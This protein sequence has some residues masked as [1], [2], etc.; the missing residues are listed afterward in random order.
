M[1]EARVVQLGSDVY[2]EVHRL[3]NG[4]SFRT[5]AV[6]LRG[7]GSVV[8]SPTRTLEPSG[9]VGAAGEPRF[10]L[11]P[12]HFHWLGIP[13]WSSA[14]PDAR[15]V[16]TERA[17]RRLGAKLR[18]EISGLAE[19]SASLPGEVALLEP[20]GVGSGE[21]WLELSEG[22][23][24]TWIVCDA[25]FNEPAHPSGFFGLGCRMTG[26]TFGLRLGQTWK[27]FQ[28]ADRA[29]YRDFVL[30]RLERAP[31]TRLVMSH[32]DTLESSELPGLLTALVRSRLG[33]REGEA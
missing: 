28:L 13:E 8:V 6:A 1:N 26:T 12:N 3:A 29:R 11:A 27:Y 21:V 2:A 10:F 22:A 32:G 24:R 16:A 7:G 17:A 14:Y 9:L 33:M 31:P 25:F 18:R 30:E 20:P 4:W 19:L 5:I 23:R 15:P